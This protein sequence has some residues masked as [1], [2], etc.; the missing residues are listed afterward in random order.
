MGRLAVLSYHSGED[1]IAKERIR[2]AET[3][4][5]EC[6][7][8]LPCVCGAV[9]TVRIV[10]G[11][12]KRPTPAEQAANRARTAPPG[13]GSPRSWRPADGDHRCGPSARPVGATTD[14]RARR[15][16]S[17]PG[18]RRFAWFAVGLTVLVGGVLIGA[19]LL[20]TRL[21]ERQLEIDALERAVR[22][23]QE[24][25]DVLRAQR[26]ELRSPTRLAVA[27]GALGMR[28]GLGERVHRRRPDG[29][30]GHDRPHR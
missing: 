10:R 12:A 18:R 21:A 24:Q 7:P 28:A 9:Q 16:R 3:G 17:C 6:P 2:H 11:I 14:G 1:R 23:E 19:V 30:G 27:A 4:G 25:F 20:H 22:V 8:E 5:C 29:A 26:A 13:C 15:W